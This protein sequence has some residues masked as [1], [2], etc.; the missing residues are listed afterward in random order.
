MNTLYQRKVFQ[1][2]SSSLLVMMLLLM[3]TVFGVLAFSATA[4][5]YRLSKQNSEQV[6]AWYALDRLGELAVNQLSDASDMVNRSSFDYCMTHGFLNANDTRLSEE[7][8]KLIVTEWTLLDGQQERDAFLSILFPKLYYNGVLNMAVDLGVDPKRLMS[9]YDFQEVSLWSVE[10]T[11]PTGSLANI[12]IMI[13]D[14]NNQNVGKL[15][16]NLDVQAPKISEDASLK[17][18]R[19]KQIQEGFQYEQKT[20]LWE[21]IVE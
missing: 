5:N 3:L 15:A 21:G 1:R 6:V 17:I 11:L 18:V 4:A 14:E 16:I 9:L 13:T 2:G 7:V 8:R 20:D 12:G 19:W 10:N